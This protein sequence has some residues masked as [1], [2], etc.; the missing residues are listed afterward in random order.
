MG[1]DVY[2][3]E[4]ENFQDT[5][6]REKRFYDEKEQ[7]TQEVLLGRRTGKDFGNLSQNQRD[8][9]N[10]A[11]E[12]L[13][14]EDKEALAAKEAALAKELDVDEHGE[15]PKKKCLPEIASK[16]HPDHYF[17]IGYMRS[18]YNDGGINRVLELRIGET[19]YSIFGMDNPRE[20]YQ[21][22]VDWGATLVRA[23]EAR[24]AL[25]KYLEEQG[26]YGVLCISPNV[27]AGP[28]ALKGISNRETALKR[29]LEERERWIQQKA[30]NPDRNEYDYEGGG[31]FFSPKGMK[32]HAAISGIEDTFHSALEM[33][34]VPATYLIFS[35]DDE[36]GEA[37]FKWYLDALEVV[38]EFCE[39]ALAHPNKD[40]LVLH[41][42]G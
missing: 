32:I 36:D 35:M 20:Y 19:L 39:W 15:C 11:W 7:M 28:D 40:K 30:E 14:D 24:D 3:Y 17:K 37:P 9:Y 22:N 2:L 13:S 18:S 25:A 6:D 4:Y 26:A 12:A 8:A 27:F 33:P 29:F 42:S 16:I 10:A 34:V 41:W 38:M 21:P 5:R 31:G 1:L 23:R